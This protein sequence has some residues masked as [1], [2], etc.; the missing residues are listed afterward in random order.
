MWLS[1]CVYKYAAFAE[2]ALLTCSR[3]LSEDREMVEKVLP[4]HLLAE[5]S[6]KAD[7]PQTAFRRLRQAS[8][9]SLRPSRSVSLNI[10]AQSCSAFELTFR[11]GEV[12]FF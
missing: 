8:L 2:M 10:L 1:A 7:L 6:V 3:I 9:L 4:E 12:A 11:K 5:M